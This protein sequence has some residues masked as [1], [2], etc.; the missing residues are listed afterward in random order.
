MEA[1]APPL[2]PAP[3]A[4]P[5]PLLA[6]FL[7]ATVSGCMSAAEYRDEADDEVYSIVRELRNG[8]AGGD[9]FTIESSGSTLRQR[10]LDGET[11]DGPMD[12]V[13]ALEVASE[14]SRTYQTRRETL[15]L[16]ALDLTLARFDFSVQETGVF[17]S[18]L[19]GRANR[20]DTAS[21]S[22]VLGIS[23]IFTTGLAVVGDLALNLVR[24]ISRGDAWDATTNLRLGITQPILR[25]FGRSIVREP[26]TQSERNVVYQ[27]RTYDRF[28]H[29]FAFEVASRYY[30]ILALMDVLENE[31]QNQKR[32]EELR[33]R[34]EA[35]AEAGLLDDIQVDQASQ[36]ELAARNSV[37]QAER[38]LASL[39]DD[40]KL[41]LGL[42]ID[43][44]LTL[45]PTDRPTLETY[46]ALDVEFQEDAVISVALSSRLDYLND[47][48]AVV[49]TIRRARIAADSLRAGLD[50]NLDVN[51]SSETN[52]PFTYDRDSFSSILRLDLDT[53][54]Q[55][56]VERNVYRQRLIE[57]DRAER[58]AVETA[59]S[60]RTE[61]R[62][63]LRNLNVARRSYEIQENAVVL[64]Q[65]R[66]DSAQL[67]L[68][69]GRAST[70]D[71]LESQDDL[72]QAQ[73]GAA[74]AR[75]DYILAGLALYVDM[76][77]I[78]V[79]GEGIQIDTEPLL[80][81]LASQQ[82]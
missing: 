1:P 35:F 14:N 54:L 75:T 68:E 59:D 53:P 28:R 69:A 77:L 32:R 81:K 34:N 66:V 47:L 48:D 5:R 52:K 37:I 41:F 31:R 55:R 56:V 27:A 7:L 29:T 78:L 49:D 38:N 8:L 82:P 17:G 39:L 65:R 60:I 46:P 2:T 3:P 72:V 79:D 42:P 62:D 40:Y 50:V 18:I 73:N 74:N 20:Q 19:D 80:S 33:E 15:F 43:T 12:L 63:S 16:T 13:T 26:L 61:L 21:G 25:G 67:K 58:S 11:L 4:R 6:A 23:K 10:L 51:F 70:R 22:G 45:D 64:A 57:L 76:E 24:D 71:L 30:R 44:N 9:S 36:N